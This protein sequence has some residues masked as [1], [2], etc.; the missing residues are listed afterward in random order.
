MKKLSLTLMMTLV[1]LFICS[2]DG[3]LGINT[4]E[5][6][7]KLHIAGQESKLR[8][9]MFDSIN[10]IS[11]RQEKN[12]ELYVDEAG[13][14]T[15]DFDLFLNTN[16]ISQSDINISS[17][18]IF[19]NG[20][21]NLDQLLFSKIITISRPA[22]L[23]IKF[24]FSFAVFLDQNENLITDNLARVIRNYIILNNDTSRK[25]GMTSKAYVNG[26][27]NGVNGVL[28]NN[29]ST[30]IFLQ[31]AGTHTINFYGSVGSGS[32]NVANSTFVRFRVAQ[33]QLLLK[34]Y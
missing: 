21:A 4:L 27:S 11:N 24:S 34:L 8:L 10:S 3:N 6:L 17:T 20:V 9:E 7:Q 12:A 14:L 23:E 15:L 2:Q 19:Q 31:N 26:N 28:F 32:T 33:D 16:E 30:Y 13:I 22:Y 18:S 29:A 5:P 1:S 25:F